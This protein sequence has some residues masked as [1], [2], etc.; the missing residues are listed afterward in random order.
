MA[1]NARV[2]GVANDKNMGVYH[3]GGVLT[4]PP[5]EPQEMEFM[6]LITGLIIFVVLMLPGQLWPSKYAMATVNITQQIKEHEALH[7]TRRL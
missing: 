4:L 1:Q 3:E 6:D 7:R 5:L 2:V